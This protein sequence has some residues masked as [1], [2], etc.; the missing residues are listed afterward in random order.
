MINLKCSFDS[1]HEANEAS[2]LLIDLRHLVRLVNGYSKFGSYLCGA[3]PEH[4]PRAAINWPVNWAKGKGSNG[5]KVAPL[6]PDV[7]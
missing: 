5:I 2:A 3:F 6:L 7:E 4:W 1:L